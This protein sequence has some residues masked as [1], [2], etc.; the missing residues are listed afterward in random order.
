MAIKTYEVRKDGTLLF[1]VQG[2]R[3]TVDG[4]GVRV[5]DEDGDVV[6]NG[7]H[8]HSVV[9]EPVRSAEPDPAP[10]E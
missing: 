4:M 3:C 8:T 2:S 1:T 10:G 5:Y 9:K 7:D 6:F